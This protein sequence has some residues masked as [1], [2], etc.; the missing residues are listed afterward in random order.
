M[1]LHESGKLDLDDDVNRHLTQ[2]QVSHRFQ[3][4][5]RVRHLLT[6]TSGFDQRFM[7]REGAR[8]SLPLSYRTTSM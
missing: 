8:V 3:E 5:V 1:Q 7:A 4:P 6:H 2:L